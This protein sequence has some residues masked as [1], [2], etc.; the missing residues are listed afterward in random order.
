MRNP[1]Y[2]AL[3]LRITGRIPH[4]IV[5]EIYS[6]TTP[7]ISTETPSEIFQQFF[8]LGI[9]TEP[10]LGSLSSIHTGYIF[11]KCESL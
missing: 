5:W 1:I 11:P 7:A 8:F 9:S 3:L 4:P 6:E 2:P 10:F